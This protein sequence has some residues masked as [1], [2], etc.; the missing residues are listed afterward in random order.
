MEMRSVDVP[1][2]SAKDCQYAY[3]TGVVNDGP[4]LCAD[5][6]DCCSC[7]G[8]SG[9]PLLQLDGDERAVQP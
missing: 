9:G 8:D 5:E 7:L 2:S 6:E 4:A 3:E 1:V